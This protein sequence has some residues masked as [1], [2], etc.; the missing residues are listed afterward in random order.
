M[1]AAGP[2]GCLPSGG[3]ESHTGALPEAWGVGPEGT[4]RGV[5]PPRRLLPGCRITEYVSPSFPASSSATTT[6]TTTT[7]AACVCVWVGGCVSWRT[8]RRPR[9]Q[10]LFRLR[11]QIRRDNPLN[12]SIL[13]SGGKETNQD[14]LSSGERR[15][16]SPAPNP[17]PAGGRGKCGVRKTACPVS[18]GGLSPSDRGSAR[19]RCEAGNGPRRAGVR[20]SRSRVVWECSPKRVVNSI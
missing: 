5:D 11:P 16:K 15:G 2:G 12:L 6:T 17:R 14:S 9:R 13:L 20:S 19:G 1:C 8:G 10:P 7:T 18:L 4:V 3:G